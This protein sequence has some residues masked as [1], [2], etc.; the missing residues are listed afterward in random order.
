MQDEPFKALAAALPH[1]V[2]TEQADGRVTYA[3]PAYS[4]AHGEPASHG[5]R[6]A[7]HP[8]DEANAREAW[9]AG[10]AAGQAFELECR[11]RNQQG[12]YRRS[13]VKAR[14]AG[15]EWVCVALDLE[16]ERASTEAHQNLARELNHR[17]KNL[18]A[19]A[20]GLVSMTARST[21]TTKE[22]AD[23]LRGRLG[24]LS[25]AH[26]LARPV[27]AADHH[28]NQAT[29]LGALVTA[30]LAPY[31]AGTS[32]RLQVN[33]PAVPVGPSA[34]TNLS[35]VLHELATNAAKYG[36]LSSERG[37]LKIEWRVDGENVELSWEESGGPR[38]AG[39]PDHEGFGGQL[40]RRS[41]S[42]QLGGALNPDWRPEGL[43]LRMTLAL[44]RLAS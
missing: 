4:A 18:F 19:I 23:A 39:P 29:T 31:V 36:A 2:W 8:E 17:V 12:G 40:A 41:V 26:E 32:E 20:S 14:P 44:D 13:C 30:I 21:T 5:W 33:G 28:L 10:V 15:A 24:A 37:R 1:P 9:R 11:L 27:L 38:L 7:V 43:Q 16:Q 22:M 25:R 3:N 34:V 42:G 35:L 6:A